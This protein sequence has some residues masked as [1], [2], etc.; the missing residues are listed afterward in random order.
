MEFV[1][2][3]TVDEIRSLILFLRGETRQCRMTEDSF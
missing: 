1:H 3:N 2:E